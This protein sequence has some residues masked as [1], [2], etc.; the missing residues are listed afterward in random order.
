MSHI[1]RAYYA[2]RGLT[3]SEGLPTNAVY[4]FATMLRKLINDEAPEYLSVALDLE[5]PT[6]R[7]EQFADY[8][9]TR[10]KMPEDLVQ[11]LPWIH[12]Q[13]TA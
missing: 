8:K 5:G 6:V 10:P 11:Q 13:R 7:H 2:I 9:A 4:G 1:Y 3:N 12:R